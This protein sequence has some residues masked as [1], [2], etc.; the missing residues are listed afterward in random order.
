MNVRECRS[1]S[2]V[3]LTL[4]AVFALLGAAGSV[5]F[6]ALILMPLP[7]AYDSF[8]GPAAGYGAAILGALV[9]LVGAA[10]WPSSTERPPE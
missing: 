8:P 1:A 5:L 4:C 6:M 10:L 3:K 2:L 7:R 9:V